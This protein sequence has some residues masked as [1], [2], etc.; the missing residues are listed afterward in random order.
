MGMSWGIVRRFCTVALLSL[1]GLWVVG[2][3]SLYL[4]RPPQKAVAARSLF[5]GIVYW[6]EFRTHPRPFMMHI[7]KV[8][9]TAPGIE[10][11]VTPGH[12]L[13]GEPHFFART[14][15][16]F[17]DEFDVQ[18]AINAGFFFPIYINHP[19]NYYPKSGEPIHILGQAIADGIEYNPGQEQWT[20]LCFNGQNRAAIVNSGKCPPQTRNAV[21]GSVLLVEGGRTV[22]IAPDTPNNE[23]L[24]PR[25]A[26]ALDKGGQTLWIVAI[27]GRQP[28]YSEGVT[29]DELAEI[30]RELGVETA[31][32]LDGGGSTALVRETATGAKPLNV[33]IHSRVP[34]FERPV[35]THLGFSARPKR[36][37]L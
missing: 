18:L 13:E 27:D 26:I 11:L 2:L 10:I 36:D 33:P 15:S 17:A 29:L 28:T 6:R 20:A 22:E 7:A 1:C 3:D 14:T 5:E 21:A 8:D 4:L 24:Y 32:N 31:L 25:T 37:R 35:A 34:T 12:F 19:W 23:G 16:E 30:V 9:L